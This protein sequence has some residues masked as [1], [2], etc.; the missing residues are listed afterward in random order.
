M[1]IPILYMLIIK[2]FRTLLLAVFVL[3]LIIKKVSFRRV[4]ILE[5]TPTKV[6]FELTQVVR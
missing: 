5:S 1:R 3:S 4:P 2:S 6:T